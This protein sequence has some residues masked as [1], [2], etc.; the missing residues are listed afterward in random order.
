MQDTLTFSGPMEASSQSRKDYVEFHAE[1]P[2]I[3][4][5]Q[6][7]IPVRPLNGNHVHEQPQ[8][9]QRDYGPVESRRPII[10][11]LHDNLKT[12]QL[13]GSM[14]MQTAYGSSYV[15][16]VE[17]HRPE[18]KRMHSTLALGRGDIPKESVIKTDFPEHQVSRPVI[19]KPVGQLQ[20][21]DSSWN[22]GARNY[23]R[24]TSQEFGIGG[25][26]IT[27]AP[28]MNRVRQMES[29]IQFGSPLAA[30]PMMSLA[31]ETFV[32]LEGAQRSRMTRPRTSNRLQEQWTNDPSMRNRNNVQPAMQNRDQQPA[33][34]P[35]VLND[36]ISKSR[37][38]NKKHQVTDSTV[39]IGQPNGHHHMNGNGNN[40]L[41]KKSYTLPA[42][43]PCPAS[44]LHV[45]DK[46]RYKFT[47]ELHNHRFYKPIDVNSGA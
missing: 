20:S 2:I 15:H 37:N 47:R 16:A 30:G 41:Y 1:R 19:M 28:S 35:L 46:S 22:N 13:E 12:G 45:D 40:S 33:T 23:R 29:S 31:Q 17:S 11:R 43:D 42:L 38:N 39:E 14:D 27:P 44:V 18:I 24:R 6:D 34:A 25:M 21:H 10:N 5:L 7:N 4:K 36:S 3:K 32:P 9:T 26:S 8:S